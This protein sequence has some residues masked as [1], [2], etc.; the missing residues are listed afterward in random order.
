MRHQRVFALLLAAAGAGLLA[1]SKDSSTGPSN[2]ELPAALLNAYCVRDIAQL[3]ETKSGVISSAD[4]NSNAIDQSDSSYY[5]VY[6][7]RVSA[8]TLVVFDANSS[9]DNFLTVLRLDSHTQTTASLTVVAQNDDR[10]YP[11]NLNALASATLQPNVDYFVSISGYNY[12]QVGSYT[13]HIYA[14]N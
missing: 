11:S 4:C 5:E 6:R 9:F 3:G 10:A 12:S 14:A 1:C 8:S 2:D 7:I 13:L